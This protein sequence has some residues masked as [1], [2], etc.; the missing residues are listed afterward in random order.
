MFGDSDY[1]ISDYV[2]DLTYESSTSYTNQYAPGSR[3][4]DLW[5]VGYGVG[6]G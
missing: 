1:D 5:N 4:D 2:S 3:Y 6:L